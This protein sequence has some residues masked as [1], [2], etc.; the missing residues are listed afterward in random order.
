MK[1]TERLSELLKNVTIG[2]GKHTLQSFLMPESIDR[3]AEQLINS[4]VFV[5]PC[6]IGD[7]LYIVLYDDGIG[8]HFISADTITAITTTGVF[9]SCFAPA[10][11][12]F[13]NFT[14]YSELGKSAFLSPDDA[15]RALAE[16][17][18]Q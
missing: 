1:Q 13:G 17:S 10:R 3:I 18:R 6:N 11:S 16:R 9:T 12:D 4:G 7:K 14:D 5:P 8:E 2:S 15:E